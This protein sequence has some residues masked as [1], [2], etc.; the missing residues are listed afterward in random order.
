VLDRYN[1][2]KCTSMQANRTLVNYQIAKWVKLKTNNKEV[3]PRNIDKELTEF[4]KSLF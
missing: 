3:A 1:V 4:A 2:N